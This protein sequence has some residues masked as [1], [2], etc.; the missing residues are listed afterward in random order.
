MIILYFSL[1][2]LFGKCLKNVCCRFIDFCF[3]GVY[4]NYVG[5]SELCLY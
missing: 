2:M 5:V 1:W 3:V 4:I